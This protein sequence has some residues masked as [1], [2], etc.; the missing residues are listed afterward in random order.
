MIT[1]AVVRPVAGTACT[2]A[3]TSQPDLHAQQPAKEARDTV[4]HATQ[5]AKKNPKP[6]K[7]GFM[8]QTRKHVLHFLR[9]HFPEPATATGA[10]RKNTHLFEKKTLDTTSAGLTYWS[11]PGRPQQAHQ[12]H[13]KFH[14]DCSWR[15]KEKRFMSFTITVILLTKPAEGYEVP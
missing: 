8:Q 11:R 1:G 9:C 12:G 3:S 10:I 7:Y 15:I 4:R 5:Q 14:H 2:D 6:S 13:Q